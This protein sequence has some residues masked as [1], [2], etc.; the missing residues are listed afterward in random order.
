MGI[1]KNLLNKKGNKKE[2]DTNSSNLYDEE[3]RQIEENYNQGFITPE[4]YDFQ[5]GLY[6]KWRKSTSP[7]QVPYK[8]VC[9]LYKKRTSLQAITGSTSSTTISYIIG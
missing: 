1:F 3:L 4:E 2:S 5:S 7:L 9:L 6:L 8:E